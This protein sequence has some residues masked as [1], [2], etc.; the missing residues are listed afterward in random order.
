MFDIREAV[1]GVEVPTLFPDA[2]R[3]GQDV[4]EYIRKI[5]FY[6]PD[7]LRLYE[8][9][10][11]DHYPRRTLYAFNSPCGLCE[12]RSLC[13]EGDLSGYIIGYSAIE[14]GHSKLFVSPSDVIKYETCPRQWAYYKSGVKSPFSSAASECGNCLHKGIEEYLLK[15]DDPV[16]VFEQEWMERKDAATITYNQKDTHQGLLEIGMKLMI[17][18]P[19]KWR[20]TGLEVCNVERT[21]RID[22]GDFHTADPFYVRLTIRIYSIIIQIMEDRNMRTAVKRKN[23]YLDE[24]KIRKVQKILGTKT[25]TETLDKALEIIMFRTELLDSLKK[26]SGKGG[27]QKV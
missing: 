18:F 13:I 10:D 4:E 11:V 16:R 21:V 27:V 26:V 8:N 1:Q 7:M 14:A 25:E 24:I 22:M 6:L 2:G 9:G 23:Y 12:Y 5:R 17:Q 3:S 20:E 19:D 15:G